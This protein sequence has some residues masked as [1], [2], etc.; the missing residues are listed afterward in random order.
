[1]WRYP[2]GTELPVVSLEFQDVDR[3][4][5][6]SIVAAGGKMRTRAYLAT[7]SGWGRAGTVDGI[8]MVIRSP[9]L[10]LLSEVEVAFPGGSGDR[11]L[12]PQPPLGPPE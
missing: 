10:L 8:P 6:R 2:D 3:R 11:S 12:Y 9:E 4:S 7:A 1:V 5:L